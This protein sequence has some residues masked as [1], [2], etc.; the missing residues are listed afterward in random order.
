MW[1]DEEKGKTT[2]GS[3]AKIS[4]WFDLPTSPTSRAHSTSKDKYWINS[5][6][7][8]KV[9]CANGKIFLCHSYVPRKKVGVN[10]CNVQNETY[11]VFL[12]FGINSE[13]EQCVENSI[14]TPALYTM[15]VLFCTTATAIKFFCGKKESS[16]YPYIVLNSLC[17]VHRNSQVSWK[18]E[19]KT[20][21]NLFKNPAPF[22]VHPLRPTLQP[23]SPQ[24]HYKTRCS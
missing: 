20:P 4:K 6:C 10:Y 8:R 22:T 24:K 18:H 16:T 23:R 11:T 13:N 21:N 2:L 3:W 17:Y 5:W 19:E 14:G 9:E 1:I 15:Y 12:A 7:A